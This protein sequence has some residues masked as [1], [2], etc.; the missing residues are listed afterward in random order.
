M[1]DCVLNY[2]MRIKQDG[3]RLKDKLWKSGNKFVVIDKDNNVFNMEAYGSYVGNAGE[4]QK[5]SEYDWSDEQFDGFDGHRTKEFFLLDSNALSDMVNEIANNPN[6]SFKTNKNN[7]IKDGLIPNNFSVLAMEDCFCDDEFSSWFLNL[8]EV[9]TAF[10]KKFRNE[11]R[12]SNAVSYKSSCPL[13]ISVD[14][15][16]FD[17]KFVSL[18]EYN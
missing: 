2:I 9:S 11:Y 18:E 4:V 12:P 8:M 15:V 7:L 3:S 6:C 10:N 14:F 5:L 13:L 1:D 17:E 16:G